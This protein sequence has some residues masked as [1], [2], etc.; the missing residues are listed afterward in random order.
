[1]AVTIYYLSQLIG[2]PVLDPTGRPVGLIGDFVV[3]L[4]TAF[5]PVTGF[6]IRLGGA[7][8][9]VAPRAS[10]VQWSQVAEVSANGL[11]LASPKLDILPFRRRPGEL[12]LDTDL[13]DQQVI[14]LNGRK[15]V[16]VNDVQLVSA[17]HGGI[18]LRLAGID[19]GTLG[20][21]RRLGLEG[22][23]RWLD[24]HTPLSVPD[25]VIPWEG[26]EPLD[27][28]DLPPELGGDGRPAPKHGLKLTHEK[29]AALHPADVADLVEQMAAPDRAA[30][31]ESLDAETA[32]ETLGEL[33][34]ELQAD[35]LEDLSP[36]VAAEILAELPPDEAADVLAEMSADRADD[37][38]RGLEPEEAEDIRELMAYDEDVA[39]GMMTNDFIA[40]SANQTADETIKTLR[41]LA[42]PAEEVYYLYVV[43][44]DMR[45]KGVLSLRDLIVAPPN[46]RLEEIIHQ[47]HEEIV[48]VPVDMEREEVIR[49]ID[50]YNLLAVPVV[51][52]AERLVGVITVDD[53]LAAALPEERRWLPRLHR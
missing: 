33:E 11:R 50:K 45:L 20:L 49:L 9:T 52:E 5:P 1:M 40:L 7:G 13:L 47:E 8:K 18:D 10:F 21:L 29:L 14:D 24:R 31:M 41:K 22:L 42:P 2:K 17:G 6:T 53:A 43:D 28:A 51:D 37:L 34:P 44:Q 16:R 12:L 4:G 15:L 19:V 26:V 32:A 46:A 38:L 36:Q 30:I 23:A 35:V 48:H 27:L 39:G 3:R 25:R